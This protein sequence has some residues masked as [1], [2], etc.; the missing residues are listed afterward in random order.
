MKEEA[1]SSSG[2]VASLAY[3]F[4]F[5]R[6][7]RAEPAEDLADLLEPEFRRVLDAAV[8]AFA[9]VSFLGAFV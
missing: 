1:K 7:V 3:L 6:C 9:P 4:L 8:P 2:L 5:G